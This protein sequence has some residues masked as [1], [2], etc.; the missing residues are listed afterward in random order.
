MNRPCE[1]ETGI[2]AALSCP[3]IVASYDGATR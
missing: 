2:G 3:A 1:N